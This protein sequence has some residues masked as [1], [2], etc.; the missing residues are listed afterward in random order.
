[1]ANSVPTVAKY[2]KISMGRLLDLPPGSPYENVTPIAGGEQ[3]EVATSHWPHVLHRYLALISSNHRQ[4]KRRYGLN[5]YHPARQTCRTP[6]EL[7]LEGAELSVTFTRRGYQQQ[8]ISVHSEGG[9]FSAAEFA[10]NPV[11]ADLLPAGASAKNRAR[12]NVTAEG[13]QTTPTPMSA[14]SSAPEATAPTTNATWAEVK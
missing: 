12:E 13:R 5:L 7:T 6:C 10:P 9:V 4:Q 2:F 3:G 11:H 8:T 1:V 14:D